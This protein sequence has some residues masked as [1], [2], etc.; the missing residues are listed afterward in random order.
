MEG[1]WWGGVLRGPCG[2]LPIGLK[3]FQYFH[4]RYSSASGY[5]LNVSPASNQNPFPLPP[6]RLWLL[7]RP[8]VSPGTHGASK[9]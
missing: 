7:T 2:Y 3:V 4:N 8:G 9:S 5:R 1:R 6:L